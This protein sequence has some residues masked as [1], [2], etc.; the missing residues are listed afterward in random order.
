LPK[1]TRKAAPG[2]GRLRFYA[3]LLP[4]LDYAEIAGS[5]LDAR[6]YGRISGASP[7]YA[8]IY[9]FI[10]VTMISAA[11]GI[12]GLVVTLLFV[13]TFSQRPHS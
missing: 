7:I 4:R 11:S 8:S 13:R 1:R 10:I 6:R 12:A 3:N 2:N 5:G 9:Q